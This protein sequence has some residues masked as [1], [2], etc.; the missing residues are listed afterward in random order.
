MEM[1]SVDLVTGKGSLKTGSGMETLLG[2][3]VCLLGSR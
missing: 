3:A 1:G 2:T